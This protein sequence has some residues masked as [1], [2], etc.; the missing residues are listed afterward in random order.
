MSYPE[1]FETSKRKL[2]LAEQNT[3]SNLKS[4]LEQNIGCQLGPQFDFK[5]FISLDTLTSVFNSFEKKKQR[6]C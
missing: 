5:L 4:Y 1:S 6:H 3:Q 2:S